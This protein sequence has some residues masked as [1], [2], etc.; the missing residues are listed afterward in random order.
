MHS[1]QRHLPLPR[2]NRLVLVLALAFA[3]AACGQPATPAPTPTQPAGG[4][5]TAV[6]AASEL[7]VGANR[8]PLGIVKNGT[9]VNNPE[10]KVHLRIFSLEGD[11][12]QAVRGEA[13]AAYR[14]EGLPF[15]L[16]VAYPS[17]DAPGAWGLEIQMTEPGAQT[18]TNRL[19]VEVVPQATTPTVGSAAFPSKNLTARDVPDL[20][21]LTSDS[22]PDPDLYQLTIADT[23]AAKKPFLVAFSTPGFCE[24]AVCAPNLQVIKQLKETFKDRIVFIHV[25]VYPYPFTESVQEQ[26]LVP[27]MAEWKLASE[28]WTFLVD[29]Q[30]VIQA[31]Y[32]GGITFAELEPALTQLAA[33]EPITA[34]AP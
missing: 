14:G 28:P 4:A 13:D 11:D 32:E 17:F 2:G 18:Q 5:L 7:T 16:Y 26:R 29:G 22:R 23:L 20:K 12:Q 24:T 6:L 33:G 8:L 21:Q 25:E 30:G 19:R 3:L 1:I 15:G 34:P 10:L 9:P 31:K 27:V